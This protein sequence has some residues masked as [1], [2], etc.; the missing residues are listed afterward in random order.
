MH[1]KL[2]IIR[3]SCVTCQAF[4]YCWWNY[5]KKNHLKGTFGFSGILY[6]AF[7]FIEEIWHDVQKG[8]GSILSSIYY[9]TLS[10]SPANNDLAD[11]WPNLY[12]NNYKAIFFL[13]GNFFF[14]EISLISP[15][16]AC[17]LWA[18][19]VNVTVLFSFAPKYTVQNP[20]WN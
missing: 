14:F 3:K 9:Q 16:N 18:L 8:S 13:D 15:K 17:F 10:V 4:G 7:L 20:L 2:K 1:E 11:L 12:C 5:I 19:C 6:L